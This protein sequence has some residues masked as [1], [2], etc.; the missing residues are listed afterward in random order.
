MTVVEVNNQ[1]TTIRIETIRL[2][3]GMKY[4]EEI[5]DPT[6]FKSLRKAEKLSSQKTITFSNSDKEILIQWK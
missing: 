2:L 5:Y 6:Y 4:L 3:D 1:E